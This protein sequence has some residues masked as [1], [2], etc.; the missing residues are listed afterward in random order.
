MKKHA[1]AFAVAAAAASL[2]SV[3]GAFAADAAAAPA[4]WS[5]TVKLSG[6]VE[7]G[8]T[9]NAEQKSPMVNFGHLFTDKTDRIL[10]NQVGVT[11][12]R[13]IDNKSATT[14]FGF[15]L[16]GMYGSDARYTHFLNLWDKS[17]DTNQFDL[18]EANV[19]AHLPIFTPGG[20]D[21]KVGSF[22]TLEGWEVIPAA[23]NNFYS[24]SYVF[25]FGIPLKHTGLMT[26]TH[27][28]PKFDLYLGVTA[29]VNTLPFDKDNNDSAAFHG[30][31]GLNLDKVT[32]LATTS[33]GPENPNGTAGIRPNHDLRYLNDVVV[34]WK[35]NDKLTAITD[36]NYIKDDAFK[37]SGGGLAQYLTYTVNDAWSVTGRAEVWR[38]GSGFFVCGFPRNDDF[39][40]LQ[41][42]Q[43]N[44][45]FCG[46]STTYGEVTFGATYKPP[47]EGPFKG[48]ML[49]PE[50]RIDHSLNGTSPYAGGTKKSQVTFGM[51]LVIPVG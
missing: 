35:V 43:T 24:K 14:D 29:G 7:A 41:K 16:Q 10:L 30:G 44:A 36:A 12:E 32:I 1:T 13:P 3:G 49:R 33:I 45:S 6:W 31:F 18:V 25:N 22:V 37:V 47:I 2:G 34:I 50:L 4:A 8:G 11:L 38:D 17:K 23:G 20:M 42:G 46:G 5:D 40:R 27:V 9:F 28:N 15:K 19:Q 21:V 51:D 48:T 39:A 26:I